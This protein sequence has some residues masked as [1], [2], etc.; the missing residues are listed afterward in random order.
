MVGLKNGAFIKVAKQEKD[1]RKYFH[2]AG[3]VDLTQI[4]TIDLSEFIKED[5]NK[6]AAQTKVYT[7]KKDDESIIGKLNESSTKPKKP[8]YLVESNSA[9][10]ISYFLAK[11]AFGE[12]NGKTRLVINFDQHEDYGNNSVFNCGTWGSHLKVKYQA[13]YFVYGLKQ[14]NGIV[15]KLNNNSEHKKD[16][17]ELLN[18]YAEIYI[19]IDMDVF[20]GTQNQQRTNWPNGNVKSICEVINLINSLKKEKIIAADIHGLPVATELSLKRVPKEVTQYLNDI[21]DLA[22]VLDSKL[23]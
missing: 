13:D 3:I 22:A 11:K 5:F 19:T 20:A 8:L 7:I 21:S 14:G 12:P 23:P 4:T 1:A 9:H 17:A 2:K 18:G 16:V 6:S 15:C 10:H